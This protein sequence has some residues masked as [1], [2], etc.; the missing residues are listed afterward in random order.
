M[1]AAT[2]ELPEL[3][4]FTLLYNQIWISVIHLVLVAGLS[5][6]FN[7]IVGPSDDTAYTN[8]QK[9]Q[10]LTGGGTPHTKE[11]DKDDDTKR[12]KVPW[13]PKLKNTLS[14]ALKAAGSPL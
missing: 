6:K 9:R 3:P 4:V 10:K 2:C 8:P 7:T 12:D 5:E 1:D 11:V 13:H 14:K